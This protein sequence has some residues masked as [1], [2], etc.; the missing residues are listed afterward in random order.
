MV[1]IVSQEIADN[2]AA[3]ALVPIIGSMAAQMA[4]D[5]TRVP[6][7]FDF[8]TFEFMQAAN[9]QYAAQDD[10]HRTVQPLTLGAV[11]EAVSIR[12]KGFRESM[13]S[14]GWKRF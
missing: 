1:A 2:V 10:E 6:D 5:T 9:A 7:D 12:F 13:V 3:L 4:V 8:T 14:M 11:A